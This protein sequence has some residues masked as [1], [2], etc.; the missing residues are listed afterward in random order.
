MWPIGIRAFPHHRERILKV[1]SLGSALDNITRKMNGILQR[2][3]WIFS[4]RSEGP[5][6]EVET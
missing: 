3:K 6:I 5:I 4:E 1:Q 2:H